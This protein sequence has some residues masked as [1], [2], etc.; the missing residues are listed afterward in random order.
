MTRIIVIGPVIA[1]LAITVPTL[2]QAQQAGYNLTVNVTSHSFGNDR[3]F[4]QVT[5]ANGWKSGG[6]LQ[7]A[8]SP[9]TTFSVPPDQGN[10]VQVCVENG[11]V[12]AVLDTNC[13]R[14]D[15]TGSD[16]TVN[17]GAG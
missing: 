17:M 8:G 6:W 5:T 3:V 14:F 1:L 11:V 2:A 13:Q 7:T 12:G 4:V 10:S 9:S 16:M 15:T